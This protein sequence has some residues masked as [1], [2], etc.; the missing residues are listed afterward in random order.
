MHE[1]SEHSL[2]EKVEK[3]TGPLTKDTWEQIGPDNIGLDMTYD[4]TDVAECLEK[5][6]VLGIPP[7]KQNKEFDI[8]I[9]P[10]WYEKSR[11]VG[12]SSPA[13]RDG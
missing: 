8:D 13:F 4:D 6:R 2:K 10:I 1:Y 11:K 3:K 9:P 12:A 7:R 5:A